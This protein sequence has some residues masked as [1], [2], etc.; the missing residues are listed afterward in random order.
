MTGPRSREAEAEALLKRLFGVVLA[1]GLTACGGS[2]TDSV[3]APT[4]GGGSPA[5]PGGANPAP[6]GTWV[7]ASH[8]DY[9]WGEVPP[10]EVPWAHMTHL[11]L[12]FLEP[13]GQ[14]GSYHLEVT[15]YGP[16]DLASWSAA[17]GQFIE[18]AHSQ[19]VQVL[20]DLGGAGFGGAVFNE[21]TSNGHSDAL[22]VA[23]VD[24]L[25]AIG[26]DGVDLDWEEDV[27]ADGVVTLLQSLRRAWPEG[28]VTVAV[29]PAYGDD[30]V[31]FAN[32]VAAAQA[33]I[34][35]VMV[36]SFG[37][38]DQTWTWWVGRGWARPVYL[39]STEP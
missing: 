17:A 22:A 35:A 36:M 33:D 8:P 30:Q 21:A 25:R 7:L 12:N 9:Q 10:S 24:N 11:V 32:T 3:T 19:G 39:S 31:A 16:P 37:P 2:S 38:P 13:A 20:C 29:E 1:I 23:I 15:G 27:R 14:D 5:S 26:F 28:I 4:P 18:A 34:D 6:A